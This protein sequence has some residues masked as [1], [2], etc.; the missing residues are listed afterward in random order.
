MT[1]DNRDYS[2]EQNWNQSH[3]DTTNPRQRPEPLPAQDVD[4]F[5]HL[6]AYYEEEQGRLAFHVLLTLGTGGGW[7]G[8]WFAW[9][10]GGALTF[11]GESEYVS[12]ET[13]RR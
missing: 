3:R 9:L 1:R 7:L 4:Y 8:F 6:F 10:A 12:Q 5:E 11:D 2:N 13:T